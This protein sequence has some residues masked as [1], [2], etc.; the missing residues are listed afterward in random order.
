MIPPIVSIIVPNYNHAKFLR[1]RM[2]SIFEQTYQDFEVILLD[3][4]S[5]DDSQSILSVYA[6]DPRV[7]LEFNDTNSGSTF[8]QWKKGLGLARGKYIW[9][10]ESDDTAESTLLER[11]VTI[12]DNDPEVA[13]AYCRSFAVE[14]SG[15]QLSGFVDHWFKHPD[16]ARWAADFCVDGRAECENHF[17]YTNPTANAS[18]VVFRKAVYDRVGGVDETQR[19]SSDWKLWAAMALNGKVAYISEPLNYYR[20]HEATVRGSNTDAFIVSEQLE[21]IRWL[22]T[23]IT[24]SQRG[25]EKACRDR[26][27]IWVSSVMSLRVPLRLKIR[28]LKSVLAVDPHPFRRAVEPALRTVRLKMLRHIRA[29]RRAESTG[30]A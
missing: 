13:F 1:E 28:I 14:A 27:Y 26:S 4:C 11:L 10:A 23:R 5:K 3:D 22:L 15:R 6:S 7:R 24:P 9:I 25:L 20:F 19:T 29:L 18:A 2:R 8:K 12:L 16:P 30:K 17:I 21:V